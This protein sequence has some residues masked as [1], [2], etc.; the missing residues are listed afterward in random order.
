MKDVDR[1]KDFAEALR[2][3]ALAVQLLTVVPHQFRNRLERR[4]RE[5]DGAHAVPVWK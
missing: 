4:A 3:T 1:R 2:S 5:R